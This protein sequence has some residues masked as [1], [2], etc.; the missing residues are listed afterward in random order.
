MYHLAICDDDVVY[1]QYMKKMILASGLNGVIKYYEYSSG[2][3]LVEDFQHNID[4]DALFLDMQMK[5]M[6][7]DETAKRFRERYRNAVLVFCSGASLPTVKT[8]EVTPYRY[9][10]KQYT[11]KKMIQELKSVAD[12]IRSSKTEAYI[13]GN[14]H[15]SLVKLKPEE[16]LYIALA[17]RG[18][19]IYVCPNAAKYEFESHVTSREKLADLYESLKEY[20]FAYAHNSYIVNLNYIKRKTLTELELFEGTVLSIAR[21]KEKELRKNLAEYLSQKY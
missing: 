8:F 3:Q 12:H 13:I 1:I 7:G 10:L 18:S 4:Y 6:D 15:Y 17:K 9:L 16:I 20:G 2:E 11:S 19:N 5:G 14:Y 21:S